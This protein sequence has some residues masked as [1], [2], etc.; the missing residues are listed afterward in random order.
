MS[1]A[2]RFAMRMNLWLIAAMSL[3]STTLAAEN[4][5]A[6]GL[7][8]NSTG[9]SRQY[10]NS[11]GQLAWENFMGDWCDVNNA[12]QGDEPYVVNLINDTD[13]SRFIQWDVTKLVAQWRNGQHQNQGF[14]LRVLRGDGVIVFCSRQHAESTQYPQLVVAGE[15]GVKT[16]TPQADTYLAESTYRSQGDSELLRLSGEPC[17][18]LIR[19]DLADCKELGKVTRATLR[20]FTI[21]QYGDAEVGV[22]RCQQGGSLSPSDPIDGLAA[23]HPN[24]SNIANDPDVIFATGF[25]SEDWDDQ[26]T[27]AGD[28]DVIDTV[29]RDPTRAFSPL[30]GKALRVKIAEGKNSA[31]NTAYKFQKEVG[32]EP[33]EVYFRYYLRL[34]DDWNQT[35][36][37]GKMPGISGTY[38]TA[39]WGG[40]K[41][42]GTDG[43]SARGSFGKTVPNDNPLGGKHPIKT[44]AYHADMKGD[45]GDSW[46]WDKGGHA[47]L[48]NNRWYCV[49]QHLKL[50]TP[51]KNDGVL[52]AWVDGRLAFEKTDIRF[53]DVSKLKIEQIWMNVYHGGKL[54]SP[55]DQHCFID[56]VVVAKKYIG[57]MKSE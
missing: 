50:N 36:Q 12:R 51:T 4:D 30:A 14:F 55:Y 49:E 2:F 45:Y 39:G 40:R 35:L 16:L 13:E 54:P 10:Y 29:H 18:L 28:M 34:G 20:L 52:Q 11:A 9:A 5:W 22:F 3:T 43:W 31:L 23:D 44:Y 57:P 56:N 19:F 47:F 38:G 53:R 37:G 7:T 26:W 21:K 1:S 24:D 8:G 46:V 48:E 25:E 27:V 6:E 17:N 33:E 42:D 15:N 32:S 41:V